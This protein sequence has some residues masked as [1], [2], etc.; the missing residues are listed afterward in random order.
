[1]ASANLSV[2]R[3]VDWPLANPWVWLGGGL[4][5][6]VWSWLWTLT[7]GAVSS[8]G[9]IIVLAIGLLLAGVGSWQRFA[10][11]GTAYV[12][13]SLPA[14]ALLLRLAMGG[15]FALIALGVSVLFVA[16][17]FVGDEIGWRSAP[18][19]LV[20]LSTA[21][22]AISAARRCLVRD[23]GRAAL[24]VEE[25]IG[26]AFVVGAMCAFAGSWTL[27]LGPGDADDWD[28]MRLFLRVLTVVAL[29]GAG[30]ALVSTRVRRLVISFLFVLHFAGISN[31][32][33]AAPP[34]PWLIQQAWMRISRPYLEFMYLNNAYHFYAP[35]PGP[36][37]YFWFRVIYTDENGIDQGWWYKVPDMDDK[38]RHHHSVAL[39]YQRHL[40]M[41]E[42]VAPYDAPPPWVVP[43]GRGGLTVSPFY[44]IRMAYQPLP[45]V[46][47][48]RAP[49]P[50]IPVH[51]MMPWAQQVIIPNEGSRRL[52]SSYARFVA[53]KYAKHPEH[54]N[55][56][57]K[58]VKVYR[59]IHSIATV[60]WFVHRYSPSDP[61]LYRPFY[62]GNYNVA[63]DLLDAKWGP[64]DDPYLYWLLPIL[65]TDP[66]DPNSE[67]RDFCR[68]HAGDSEWIR[69]A[70]ETRWVNPRR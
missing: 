66:N 10:D 54:E 57:F 18:T 36:A 47:D 51:P 12:S 20:W 64:N 55:W 13:P 32:C 70:G 35:D 25:E 45:T 3:Q 4:A 24:D 68:R 6:C 69:P 56:T 29:G 9:R 8:E 23:H 37:S 7:F 28:T 34:A 65:R 43:D 21:P 67:I 15:L 1:M 31:A 16:T 41:T 48:D 27:Y 59:V 2:G 50:R 11:R 14:L 22:L 38:G 17:F 52:L 49:H 5:L 33:L 30:L 26:L 44:S 46:G 19:L 61:T 63:G 58:S 42:S 60:E 62:M 39:E 53:H 40:A